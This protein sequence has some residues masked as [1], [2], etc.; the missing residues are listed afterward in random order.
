MQLVVDTNILLA[1]LLKPSVTQKL[2]FSEELQLFL[3]EH[4]L[5]EIERHATEFAERMG[6]SEQEFQQ[7]VRLIILNVK[8]VPSEEYALFEQK[9]QKLCPKGHENDWPFIALA[10]SLN[11]TL[12]SNDK[13]LKKQLAVQVYATHDL[14]E[15]IEKK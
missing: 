9:A 10:L 15:K 5:R 12:W 4:S 3:P 13:A 6:A 1:G 8:I 7:A 14:M 11:C 2:L